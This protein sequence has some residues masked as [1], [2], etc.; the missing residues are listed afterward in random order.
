MFPLR[1]S[2]LVILFLILATGALS[3]QIPSLSPLGKLQQNIGNTVVSVEYERPLARGR[4][5]YGGLV[6]LNEVWRTGAGYCTK[7]RFSREVI[8]GGQ[9]VPAG[10]YAL[11][12]IPAED[13]WIIMINADTTLYGSRDYDADLDVARFRTRPQSTNRHY[14][15]MTI[16]LDLEQDNARLY[17]SWA[18]TQISFPI[19][20]STETECVSYID[21]L[22]AR[23][24]SDTTD[25]AYAAEYLFFARGDMNKALALTDRQLEAAENEYAYSMRRQIFEHLGYQE[26]ALAEV[27]RAIAYRKANP[28]DAANQAWSLRE[29][30]RHE[31]RLR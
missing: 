14:E 1:C 4:V 21:G 3:G 26:K 16:D 12:S 24:L 31:A 13:E 27:R 18:G 10:N 9:A 5:V 7:L 23:P 2:I 19:A 15:A 11:L 17:L 22:L 30:G 28:L 6:P 29:W 8:V 25:Y 20:T